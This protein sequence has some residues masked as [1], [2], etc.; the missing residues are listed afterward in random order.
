[1]MGDVNLRRSGPPWRLIAVLTLA[2]LVVASAVA[3]AVRLLNG[4][5]TSVHRWY[6][7]KAPNALD[8]EQI[9][10]EALKMLRGF[11][12]APTRTRA[13]SRR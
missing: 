5:L 2:A 3:V 11:I 12:L 8:A 10:D 7:P 6:S 13:N 4:M 1:M 9:A